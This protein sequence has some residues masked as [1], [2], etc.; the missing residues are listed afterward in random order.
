MKSQARVFPSLREAINA[1]AS[2]S[3]L[4]M[5]VLA[6]ELD[7]SPSE[8][9]MRTTLGGDSGRAFPADDE[10]LVKLQR[11][12]GDFS[13]LATMAD[14]CGFELQ[15]KRER[16]AEMMTSLQADIRVIAPKIQ[17]VLEMAGADEKRSARA[18]R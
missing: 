15:P 17:M 3:G 13:I 12:T 4:S 9:S 11:V 16:L 5:K 10:H 2:G 8:L 6:A 7:W 14:L 1:T 18:G